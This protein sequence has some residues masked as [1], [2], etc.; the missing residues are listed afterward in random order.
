MRLERADVRFAVLGLQVHRPALAV[1]SPY[2]QVDEE[3]RDRRVGHRD[4][5]HEPHAS[6][7]PVFEQHELGVQDGASMTWNDLAGGCDSVKVR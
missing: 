3:V 6:Q 4:A 1:Q 7:D 5:V 2:G